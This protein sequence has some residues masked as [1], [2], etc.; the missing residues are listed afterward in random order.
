MEVTIDASLNK[1]QEMYN[2]M[3]YEIGLIKEPDEK[4]WNREFINSL[5]TAI[6]TMCKY[7]QLQADY[8]VRLK[9][10]MIA[11]LTEIQLKI[12]EIR[13]DR[14]LFSRGHECYGYEDKTAKDM[15]E[16]CADVIQ[17]KINALKE[18]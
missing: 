15:R 7:Q 5:E 10:D 13:L 4:A 8:E 11:M 18:Q 17:E 12:E 14:P 16:D 6:D 2:I 1:L 3:E 9:A